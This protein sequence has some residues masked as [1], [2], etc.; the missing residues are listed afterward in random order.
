MRPIWESNGHD[1]SLPVWRLEFQVRR[2]ALRELGITTVTRLEER[3][4]DLW[5]YLARRWLRLGIPLDS[6]RRERWPMDPTWQ[7]LCN[8]PAFNDAGGELVR[9]RQTEGE[10]ETILRGVLGYLT[11]YGAIAPGHAVG[12]VSPAA[13]AEEGGYNPPYPCNATIS[14]HA[15]VV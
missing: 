9:L 8:P 14:G 7:T 6:T 1:S 12:R 13:R 4:S 11:S 3:A 10:L 15:L 2:E 5:A